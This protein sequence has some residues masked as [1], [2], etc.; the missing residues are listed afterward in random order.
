[1]SKNEARAPQQAPGPRSARG[2]LRTPPALRIT[3][4]AD[5][6]RAGSLLVR[7]FWSSAAGNASS[8]V[9]VLALLWAFAPVPWW[10]A[11]VGAVVLG[12]PLWVT[13]TFGTGVF[14]T[15]R[16]WFLPHQG[17][18]VAVLHVRNGHVGNVCASPRHK[19]HATTLL[20]RLIESA[21]R[22]GVDLTLTCRRPLALLYQRHQFVVARDRRWAPVVS[23]R[24]LAAERPLDP[25]TTGLPDPQESP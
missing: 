2:G 5:R 20:H 14:T 13:T 18:G 3:G 21:D 25:P 12:P 8:M 7:G 19:G 16:A 23:M 9:T 11:I 22:D 24:R 17:V 6:R 10:A 4:W 15:R 1:M